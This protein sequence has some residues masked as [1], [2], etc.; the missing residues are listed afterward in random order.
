MIYTYGITENGTL[1]KIPFDMGNP[2]SLQHCVWIDCLS[3]TREEEQLIEEFFALELPSKEEMREIEISSR[4]YKENNIL[5]MTANIISNSMSTT[6]KSEAITFIMTKSHI[7][8]L[9]YTMPRPFDVFATRAASAPHIYTS[10]G[11]V[12]I[13]LLDTIIDRSADILEAV[14]DKSDNISEKLFDM[15]LD[16]TPPLALSHKETLYSIGRSNDLVAKTHQSLA[17]THRMVK[18]FYY[19]FTQTPELRKLSETLEGDITSLSEYSSFLSNKLSFQL[20]ATLG[21]IAGEQNDVIKIISVATVIF[22]PPTL[23]ASIY[24]MNFHFMPELS[25]RHGYLWAVLLMLLSA[26]TSFLYFKKKKWL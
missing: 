1:E 16:E 17:S 15:A 13:G 18:F 14:S 6:P 7:I 21:R 26:L 22:L 20:D 12:F 4:L 2:A 8:T 23:I 25:W 24:G 3:I 11:A 9:R 19:H 5:Y 10:N